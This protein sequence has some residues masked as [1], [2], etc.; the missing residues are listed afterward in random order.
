[1]KTT[2]IDVLKTDPSARF[3]WGFIEEFYTIGPYDIVKY[4]T[5]HG[6]ETNYHGWI[7]G[8]DTSRGW[9]TLDRAILGLL[10]YKHDG[11]NSQAGEL[12]SRMLGLPELEPEIA[13]AKAHN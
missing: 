6:N 2:N 8:K 5:N 10:A 9:T 12:M 11:N 13:I 4:I 7:N 3:T 1:M